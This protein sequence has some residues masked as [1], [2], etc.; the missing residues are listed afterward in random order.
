[1][2]DQKEHIETL[3]LSYESSTHRASARAVGAGILTVQSMIDEVQKAFS[4]NER[5]LVKARP[6]AEG[7]LEVPLDLIVLG[8][9]IILQEYPL[10]QKARDVIA[11]YFDIKKRLR[12]RPVDVEDGN[13]VVIDNSPIHVD[14][15]TLQFLDPGSTVSK[16]CS[17]AFHAIEEDSDIRAVRVNSSASPK[18]LAHVPREEFRYYHPETPIGQ[19]SL[20]PKQEETR[21][22]LIVRQ[23]AFEADLLWRFVWHGNKIR[24]KM[25][26]EDFQKR[27]EEGKESFAAGDCL[28]VD[29]HR[30]LEYD[31]AVKTHVYKE[32]TVTRVYSHKRRPKE[33]TRELFDG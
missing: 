25:R 16:M 30:C 1:M 2:L 31:P 27:V 33:Q 32:Y 19:Q 29:L 17:D 23:P 15:I 6:F 28:E 9:A 26:A 3:T 21:E 22:K 14:E 4:E 12:G 5:I 8:A 7:S 18:P 20:G 13:V 24:A 10:L 11:Q